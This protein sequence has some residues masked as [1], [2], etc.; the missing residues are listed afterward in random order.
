LAGGGSSA[1]QHHHQFDF[2]DNA[3]RSRLNFA[4][5]RRFLTTLFLIVLC[6]AVFNAAAFCGTPHGTGRIFVLMVWDG[7]RPD[8]VTVAD[9]P[10]LF[11]LGREGARFDR[12][13]SAYP[14]LTMVNAAAL[15][16]GADPQING[17]MGNVLFF[18]PALHLDGATA[19]DESLKKVADK[20]TPLENSKV[21]QQLNGPGLFNGRLLRLDTIVQEIQREGGYTAVIGKQG[22]AFL[23]DNRIGFSSDGKP[24]AAAS[25]APSNFLLVSDDMAEPD[26]QAQTLK[27]AM[28]ALGP[29][30]VPATGRDAW[31]ANLVV[32]RAL[33]AAKASA[34]RGHPALIV[35]WQH[36]PDLTQHVA[37]LG[38]IPALS[39][40]RNCDINLGHIRAA[41]RS[42]GIERMTNL[43]VVSDHGFATMAMRVALSELLVKAGL[44]KSADSK[45]V[46]VAANGGTDLIYVDPQLGYQAR[47]DLLQ[48]IVNFAAAQEWCGPIFSQQPAFGSLKALMHGSYPSGIA[49]TLSQ[50][51]AKVFSVGRAPDLVLSFREISD[52]DNST[53]TG[54]QNRAF[55]IGAHGQQPV[56]N[57]SSALIHPVQGV[58]YAD[59]S[60]TGFTTGMGMHG[61]FGPRELHNFGAAIGPDFRRA[62]VDKI[63]SGN[64]DVA[65]T[66]SWL[67]GLDI[68]AGPGGIYPNGRV[69]REAIVNGGAAPA[70]SGYNLSCKIELQGMRVQTTLYVARAGDRE[71][72]DDVSVFRIPLGRSP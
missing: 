62:F 65:P 35:L 40:L 10:N 55:W 42:L 49:G 13:H 22:P 2:I 36:D 47:H 33:P 60:T 38:T 72:L 27:A 48:K 51:V 71:Y 32:D 16:T 17:I 57:K 14:T 66:I 26:D 39:A 24:Q 34:E 20:P 19:T 43:M 58:I 25:N 54:P 59:T 3:D 29:N 18:G 23:F 21:L 31:F 11:G 15:S 1:P 63:P 46:V 5:V 68:N 37:G 69:M 9:T 12:H 70:I 4:L 28:P 56:Q 52:R 64:V 61:A 7:L 50:S 53:F 6:L 30:Q 44:K 41:I 67:L 45:D 8:A